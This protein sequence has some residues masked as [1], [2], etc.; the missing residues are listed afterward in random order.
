MSISNIPSSPPHTNSLAARR[1]SLSASDPFGARAHLS[2]PSTSTLTIV[3]VPAPQTP[4]QD[5]PQLQ[6]RFGRRSVSGVQPTSQPTPNS[7]PENRLSF[8]FSSFGHSPSRSENRSPSSSPTTSPHLRPS[9]P[10]RFGPGLI[11]MP[12][13]TADQLVDLARHATNNRQNPSSPPPSSAPQS[14]VSPK[15]PQSPQTQHSAVVPLQTSPATFTPLPHDIYLPFIHRTEEV[16]AL[17]STPPSAKLFALLSQAFTKRFQELAHDDSNDAMLPED[18][19]QWTYSQLIHHLTKIDRDQCCDALWAFGARKC[20]LSHSEL[21]WERVKAAFGVPPELDVDN[22]DELPSTYDDDTHN[23]SAILDSPA[24]DR[25]TESEPVQK[26]TSSKA[27]NTTALS[28]RLE[29]LTGHTSLA[30]LD[31]SDSSSAVGTFG[32]SETDFVIGKF[33]PSPAEDEP[34]EDQVTIEPLLI[35]STTSTSH[36]PPLSLPASLSGAVNDVLGDIA[37]SAEDEA[38]DSENLEFLVGP[39]EDPDLISPSQIQGLR[40]T[41]SSRSANTSA[42]SSPAGNTHVPTFA[43]TPL[44]LDDLSDPSKSSPLDKAHQTTASSEI[45]EFAPQRVRPTSMSG[46]DTLRE[47]GAPF[48]SIGDRAPGHPLFISNFTRLTASPTLR[49]QYVVSI[50]H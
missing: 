37:E 31:T 41:T 17:I 34:Y 8:A 5:P 22:K 48:H 43:H 38:E 39:Q 47:L 3:R 9:S 30:R 40:I 14:P 33:S 25:S 23:D 16:S 21:I 28:A 27:D 42:I 49:A 4:P 35:N 45:S 10:N 19:S 29:T 36:P 6:R 18:P 44:S 1:G 20:I 11:G 7:Q 50:S 26:L 12:R 46:F 32:A 24:L 15:R 2:R 13:L